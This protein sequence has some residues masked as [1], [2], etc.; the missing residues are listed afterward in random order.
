MPPRP[1]CCPVLAAALCMAAAFTACAPLAPPVDPTDIPALER[2]AQASPDDGDAL[3]RLG[4]AYHLDGR[5]EEARATLTRAVAT[6]DEPDVA[7]LYLGLASEELGEWTAARLAYQRYLED[8]ATDRV[9]GEIRGR[10]ALVAREELKVE[11]RRA[12]EREQQLAEQAPTPRT[13]AVFPFRVLTEDERYQP[14]EAALADMVTTDLQ[15]SG[16]L[17]LLERTRV[18]AL[19]DE[20]V[21]A[22]GGFTDA[23]TGARAGRLLRAAHVVQGVVQP[24]GDDVRMDVAVVDAQARSSLGDLNGQRGMSALFDLEKDLVLRILQLLQVQLTPQERELIAGNRTDNLIAFLAYGRG[25]QA[26][27]RGDYAGAAAAF[28]E[29]ASL[30][31]G[32]RAARQQLETTQQLQTAATAGTQTLAAQ[33]TVEIAAQQVA[34]GETILTQVTGDINSSPI[35]QLA[36]AG[37]TGQEATQS[38]TERNG[39][40]E[41]S[42]SEGVSE[43][44]RAVIQITIQNPFANGVRLPIILLPGGGR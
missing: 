8:G 40:Q 41:A 17:T 6:G 25:L 4:V 23:E 11:A 18:Q 34:G 16:G 3:T 44:N 42:G 7:H 32:F 19:L 12:L 43:A 30:D 9:A 27:D 38:A 37:A 20:M 22:A 26:L 13:V 36:S 10:L 33:A 31:P 24:I 28:G 21:L 2:A 29:S 15:L 1:P 35:D 14:L 39:V 5:Y